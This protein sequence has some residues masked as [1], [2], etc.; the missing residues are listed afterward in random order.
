M[1]R[2]PDTSAGPLT[3]SMDV[4]RG[5][6]RAASGTVDAA[7]GPRGR[8]RHRRG[9]GSPVIHI[10]VVLSNPAVPVSGGETFQLGVQ[11][12]TRPVRA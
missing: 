9:P 8:Q 3:V 12:D 1:A 10:R 5:R 6:S 4:G 11:V 2:E 7:R